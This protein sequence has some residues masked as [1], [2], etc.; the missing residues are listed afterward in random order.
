MYRP[1]NSSIDYFNAVLA[2]PA[3]G[4]EQDWE[5]EL[6]DSDR[7]C[8]FVKFYE[9]NV[10]S[11]E[12]K[13]ALMALILCSLEDLSY[14]QTIEKSLWHRVQGLLRADRDLLEDIINYWSLGEF[15]DDHEH[16]NITALVRSV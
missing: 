4:S 3:T 7:V 8:E 16:F 11:D 1:N 9:S 10:L 5:V 13:Y 2:L 12:R 6:A 14:M 15:E